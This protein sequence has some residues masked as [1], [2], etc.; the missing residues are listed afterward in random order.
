[1]DPTEKYSIIF[2]GERGNCFTIPEP[3]AE[4]LLALPEDKQ[5]VILDSLQQSET[6]PTPQSLPDSVVKS[7]EPSIFNPIFK[8]YNTAT[9]WLC[10]SKNIEFEKFNF[11]QHWSMFKKEPVNDYMN[12][13]KNRPAAGNVHY[14]Y[15]YLLLYKVNQRTVEEVISDFSPIIDK[16]NDPQNPIQVN[17][18]I[19]IPL[20]LAGKETLSRDHIVGLIIKDGIIEYFDSMAVPS[21]EITLGENSGTLREVLEHFGAILGYPIIEN[22]I[23]LQNDIHNCGVFVC[24]FFKRRVED[25]EPMGSTLLSIGYEKLLSIR[26]N[27]FASIKSTKQTP[28]MSYGSVTIAEPEDAFDDLPN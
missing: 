20:I 5:K 4:N 8:L 18:P 15:N 1:M 26:E 17:E 12:Y 25:Q 19:C 2:Q 13:L 10:Q 16:L 7:S 27:I 23:R 28:F 6:S 3:V 11:P 21:S 22:P 9:T 24:N 14:F